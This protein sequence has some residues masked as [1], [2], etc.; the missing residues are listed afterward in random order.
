MFQT[1]GKTA[2]RSA[3]RMCLPF[4][5][6]VMKIMVL[7]GVCPPKEGTIL[8]RQRIISL[9]SLQM[10][11]SH[12]SAERKNH[13]PSKTPKSKS[14]QH[15]APSKQRSATPTIPRQT[16]TAFPHILKPQSTSTQSGPSSSHL[17]RLTT[18]VEGL[19]KCISSLANVIY[20]T[21]N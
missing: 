2:S 5:S 12:S 1:M 16:E 18:L 6:L 7:K 15:A 21:N 10:S 4:Y 8:L 14:S 9:I 13:S 3:A 11:E 19:H 20:S 17:D